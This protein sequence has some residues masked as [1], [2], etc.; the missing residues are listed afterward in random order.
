MGNRIEM[1]GDETKALETRSKVSPSE[2]RGCVNKPGWRESGRPYELKRVGCASLHGLDRKNSS[3]LNLLQIGRLREGFRGLGKRQ[4]EIERRLAAKRVA[5]PFSVPG[6]P[7][8]VIVVQIVQPPVMS[9]KVVQAPV[10]SL[11][12]HT[13]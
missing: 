4:R 2:R 6:G 9:L 5:F 8:P 13:I 1:V 12:S 11:S 7:T 10:M 3:M